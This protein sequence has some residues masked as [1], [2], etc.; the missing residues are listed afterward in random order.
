MCTAI[1]SE[2]SIN[3]TD[4]LSICICYQKK[5]QA[6]VEVPMQGFRDLKISNIRMSMKDFYMYI[7]FLINYQYDCKKIFHWLSL[8]T[9]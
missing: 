8:S 6:D 3:G 4:L 2:A 1:N 7:V 9:I 5:K